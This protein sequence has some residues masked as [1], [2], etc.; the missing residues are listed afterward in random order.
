MYIRESTIL[1]GLTGQTANEKHMNSGA[2]WVT[3]SAVPVR[4]CGTGRQLRGF[5]SQK[6]QW[7]PGNDTRL[8]SAHWPS[9]A[10]LTSKENQSASS[11]A[12]M[13]HQHVEL[14]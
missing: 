12:S 9:G 10:H 11:Q 1:M 3:A 2:V 4:A 7:K 13:Q 5:D 8:L 14:R 6:G